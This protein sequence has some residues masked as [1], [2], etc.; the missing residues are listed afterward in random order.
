MGH[1]VPLV[2]ST[3][4]SMHLCRRDTLFALS[5]AKHATVFNADWHSDPGS[6]TP[7]LGMN[8]TAKTCDQWRHGLHVACGCSEIHDAETE[9]VLAGDHRIGDECLAALL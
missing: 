6:R 8:A 7:E 3:E 9:S 2:R 4:A 5:V 1:F